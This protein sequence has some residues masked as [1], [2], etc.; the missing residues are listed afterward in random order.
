MARPLPYPGFSWSFAQHAAGLKPNELYNFLMCAAPFEGE[1]NGSYDEKITALMIAY[2]VLTPNK[3]GEKLDAWRD[4]QQ[5]LAELGLIY[6]TMISPS[7]KLTEA[8]HMFLAG[9]LG[10]SELIG[11][12][13]LRYQY[14]NGQKSTISKEIRNSL[15]S[16]GITPSKNLTEVQ[17]TSGVLI[18]PGTLMLRILISLFEAGFKPRITTSEC[19]TFLLPCRTNAEWAT[20]LSEILAH[21]KNNSDISKINP[22]TRRNIQEWLKFLMQSDLFESDGAK[23]IWLSDTALANLAKLKEIC[24]EQ[25]D[26]STFWIP[27]A[28]DIPSRLTWFDWFGHLPF[29]AQKLLQIAGLEDEYVKQNYI[30]GTEEM[31]EESESPEM[32]NVCLKPLDLK[33]LCRDT[34]FTFSDDVNALA[35]SLL[36]G[37]QKRHAKTLLHDRIIMELAEI[38]I[39]QGASVESDPDSIDLFSVWPSG[40]SAIF[41][42]KTVTR[43]SLQ[44]RLRTAVGQVEE[45]AYR[46]QRDGAGISDRVVVVNTEL[47]S[48]AWQADFLNNYLDIGLICK[49]VASYSAF[50]PNN[51]GTKEHWIKLGG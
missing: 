4:Y 7:L 27:S 17:A 28:Y 49:P 34:P 51:A 46:R 11:I 30:A 16:A 2:D 21:R 36:Q 14:P 18:K 22:G 12:Q 37:A 24:L 5:L 19:Q 1:K 23:A 48:K 42:I 38:F 43:R 26:P 35:E 39:A 31:D 29:N 8:G 40:K 25:E 32:K 15:E 9:G 33:K 41:E 6:S 44:G 3:R 50:A 20:A 47:D 10:F 45:Y 13:S